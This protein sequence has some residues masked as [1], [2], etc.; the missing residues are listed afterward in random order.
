MGMNPRTQKCFTGLHTHVGDPDTF[1]AICRVKTECSSESPAF[2]FYHCSSF[3]LS[4]TV[5]GSTI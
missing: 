2:F 4:V 5:K 3:M 1:F